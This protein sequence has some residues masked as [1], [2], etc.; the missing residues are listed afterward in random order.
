MDLFSIGIVFIT[1][2]MVVYIAR[3]LE[4][5]REHES[6]FNLALFAVTLIIAIIFATQ[7]E[8]YNVNFFLTIFYSF[9]SGVFLVRY[10]KSKE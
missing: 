6:R 5:S 8:G 3:M 4:K 2:F 9:W 10:I 1:L 7:I